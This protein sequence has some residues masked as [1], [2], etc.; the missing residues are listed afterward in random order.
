MANP[1]LSFAID[2]GPSALSRETRR[3]RVLSPRAAKTG[4]DPAISAV[5]PEL[6]GLGKVFLDQRH[7]HRPAALV[8]REGLRPARQRY[9]IESGFGDGQQDAIRDVGEREH[10]EC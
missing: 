2:S 4:A 9:A 1:W 10:D 3:S 7:D 5:V 6:R 8:R